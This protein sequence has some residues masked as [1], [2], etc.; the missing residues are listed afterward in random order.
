MRSLQV[1]EIKF[2]IEYAQMFHAEFRREE[3]E[4]EQIFEG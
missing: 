3:S 4:R 1:S 2:E